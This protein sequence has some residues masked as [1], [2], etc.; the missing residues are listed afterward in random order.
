MFLK[1]WFYKEKQQAA[2]VEIMPD[3]STEACHARYSN[4][5]LRRTVLDWRDQHIEAVETHLSRELYSLYSLL[6]QQFEKMAIKDL[7]KQKTF[8]ERYIEPIYKEWI[9]QE[10]ALLVQ[11]AQKDL[12]GIFAHALE[13]SE[14]QSEWAQAAEGSAVKD[15]VLTAA[16]TGAGIAAI[17]SFAMMSVVSAGGIMGFLGATTVALPV[18]AVGVAITGSLLAFGGYKA[19]SLRSRGVNRYREAV[20]QSIQ[21]Q[22]LGDDTNRESICHRLQRYIQDTSDT[23][24]RE[25]D[26]C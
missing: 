13:Y 20:K 14:S 21:Q 11:S 19:A 7:F 16:L 24:I 26:E 10:T 5:N 2:T 25:I 18:V 4:L 6:D 8:G 12:A 3:I 22:V 9:A 1:K 15:A 17:P 23:I